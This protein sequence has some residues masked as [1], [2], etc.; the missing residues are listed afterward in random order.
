MKSALKECT[1]ILLLILLFI[2]DIGSF[3]SS[4][5]S[6]H[7]STRSLKL[8]NSL[9]SL[10]PPTG[11]SSSTQL[12]PSETTTDRQR[13][14]LERQRIKIE[15]TR[16]SVVHFRLI[17]KIPPH[18]MISIATNFTVPNTSHWPAHLRGFKLGSS[19]HGLRYNPKSSHLRGILSELGIKGA[20][21]E[22]RFDTFLTALA[23]YR[24]LYGDLAVPRDFEV[25]K[26]DAW[27]RE[28][29]GMRLGVVT[30]STRQRKCYR[31]E[32]LL[33]LHSDRAAFESVLA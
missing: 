17:N 18:K 29:W 22:Q 21:R 30:S 14:R 24:D 19:L 10:K 6:L 32:V 4:R 8:S 1:S 33:Y 2:Q 7:G 9:H 3:C 23:V 25:P 27:P 20:G 28:T 31:T 12:T 13:K 26:S 15:K 5:L 16:E 11:Q